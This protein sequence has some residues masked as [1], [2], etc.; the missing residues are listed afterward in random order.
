MAYNTATTSSVFANNAT[1]RVERIADGLTDGRG[2][3]LY[4]STHAHGE[5]EATGF[6][7]DGKRHG[8]KLGDA[9]LNIAFSSDGSSAATWH[10][11]SASTGA[12]SAAD[13]LPSSAYNQ[14]FN[15]SVSVAST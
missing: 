7:A 8:L 4:R 2:V 5:I 10:V 6:F 15:V 11:V 1:P 9:L 3:F 13:P 12:I 14:A